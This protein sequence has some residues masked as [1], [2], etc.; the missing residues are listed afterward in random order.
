MTNL[1]QTRG[2]QLQLDLNNARVNSTRR[3]TLGHQ[4]DHLLQEH[5]QPL[6]KTQL[7]QQLEVEGDS[8]NLPR[9]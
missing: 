5:L 9:L 3:S 4:E 8:L 7:K 2:H 6:D 1:N